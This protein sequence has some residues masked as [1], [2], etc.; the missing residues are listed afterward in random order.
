MTPKHDPRAMMVRKTVA[1]KEFP[2]GKNP[3]A[4]L[5]GGRSCW[6]TVCLVV[7]CFALVLPADL[8]DWLCSGLGRLRYWGQ[9]LCSLSVSYMQRPF[10]MSP[11]KPLKREVLLQMSTSSSSRLVWLEEVGAAPD[12]LRT[13]WLFSEWGLVNHHNFCSVPVLSPH[14]ACG[15]DRANSKKSSAIRHFLFS[16]SNF[17]Y[18][19]EIQKQKSH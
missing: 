11:A 13:L 19:T 6:R 12:Q 1:R 17:I 7:L 10:L 15:K 4:G 16:L 8:C 5:M 9:H 2:L 18:N 14:R 3:W